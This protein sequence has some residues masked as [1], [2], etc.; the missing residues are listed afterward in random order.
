MTVTAAQK[1]ATAISEAGRL[2]VFGGMHAHK[3]EAGR[4]LDGANRA[5]LARFERRVEFVACA[6]KAEDPAF[7]ERC[8]EG[9]KDSFV[10]SRGFHPG[11]LRVPP[12]AAKAAADG[13]KAVDA[14][15]DPKTVANAMM[16]AIIN[17][18]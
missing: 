2:S 7:V 11:L 13:I 15:A 10:R 6:L 17:N 18:I 12:Q 16:V 1:L 8:L 14:G 3:T 9:G 4:L 5:T